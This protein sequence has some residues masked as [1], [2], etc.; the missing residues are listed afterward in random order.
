MLH[1]YDYE[2]VSTRLFPYFQIWPPILVVT[3]INIWLKV[4]LI[5][6]NTILFTI[7]FRIFSM[8]PNNFFCSKNYAKVINV[9]SRANESRTGLWNSFLEIKWLYQYILK[10][11]NW[12]EKSEWYLREQLRSWPKETRQATKNR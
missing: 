7:Y 12:H 10:C 11:V 2:N 3:L 6:T 4:V 9:S 5:S 1:W 8:V